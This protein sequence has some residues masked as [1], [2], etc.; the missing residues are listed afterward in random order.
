MQTI[1]LQNAH[2]S[3]RAP[4]VA[5]RLGG[6]PFWVGVTSLSLLALSGVLGAVYATAG[7]FGER[8]LMREGAHAEAEV[9]ENKTLVPVTLGPARPGHLVTYRFESPAGPVTAQARLSGQ[10]WSALRVG[11]SLGVRYRPGQPEQ[12]LPEGATRPRRTW[13]WGGLSLCWALFCGL[14][15]GG[16]VAARRRERGAG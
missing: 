2:A 7:E 6:R 16:L 13:L 5:P 10:R 1:P 9:L 12:N 4:R 8:E 11:S 15:L 3:T 14:L